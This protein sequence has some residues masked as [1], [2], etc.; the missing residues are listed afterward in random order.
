MRR[1]AVLH[2]VAFD[3]SALCQ[4][5]V[6][7][8]VAVCGLLYAHA[9]TPT[10]VVA[11]MLRLSFQG[12]CVLRVFVVRRCFRLVR[13]LPRVGNL[14]GGPTATRVLWAKGMTYR[15]TNVVLALALVI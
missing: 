4:R 1:H 10:W 12:A 2:F 8:G 13:L 11:L 6:S 14:L 3:C 7:D 9:A 5:Y 15:L